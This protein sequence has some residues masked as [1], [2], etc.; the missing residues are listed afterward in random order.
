MRAALAES[1]EA[2]RRERAELERRVA[3]R[4]RELE[5]LYRKTISAQ[6]EERQRIARELHDETCQA[7]VA[8]VLRFEAALALSAPPEVRQ[9]LVEGKALAAAT[10]DEVH[11][12]IFDLRPSILDD[13]GLVPAIRWLADRQL[14]PLGI[15]VRCELEDLDG[16]LG[17]EVETALFRAIQEALA[18]VARHA[19]AEAVLIQLAGRDHALQIE[20]EDDGKGFDPAIVADPAPSGRGL[21]LMGIRERLELVGGRAHIDSSPGHGT[22]VTLEVPLPVGAV[23][24]E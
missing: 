21:G 5:R 19:E 7:L 2:V 1:L 11:R 10:L 22:R 17:P 8:L 12:L 9:R 15:A 6:E 3:E 13:L 18:N 24:R 20:I 14:Q 23:V 4:T 16:R